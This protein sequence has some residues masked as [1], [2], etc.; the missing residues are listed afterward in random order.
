MFAGYKYETFLAAGM[1]PRN[2]QQW[3]YFTASAEGLAFPS[4]V[5][6]TKSSTWLIVPWNRVGE[7]KVSR[8]IRNTKGPSIEVL[9]SENEKD[10]Y[11]PEKRVMENIFGNPAN[12]INYTVVGYSNAF[13]NKERTVRIINELKQKYT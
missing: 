1:R 5:P 8:F 12:D 11:F 7:I 9:I 2:W 6:L 4:D 13:I 3:T 10:K